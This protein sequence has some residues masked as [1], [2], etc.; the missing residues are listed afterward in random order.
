MR[1]QIFISVLSICVR[2]R[3]KE[4]VN[5]RECE[6]ESEGEREQGKNGERDIAGK[7]NTS[8]RLSKRPLLCI[9][10]DNK[11]LQLNVSKHK[12]RVCKT[13]QE[14]CCYKTTNIINFRF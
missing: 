1:V 13:A 7:K 11:F 3:E 12:Q 10:D 6:R 14:G 5:V 9:C 8:K 2:E 4:R